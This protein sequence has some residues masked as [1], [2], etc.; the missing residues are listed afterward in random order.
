MV[1]QTSCK[2]EYVK[3]MHLGQK[4]FR[5]LTAAGK[6]PNPAA[7]E[8]LLP[9]LSRCAVTELPVQEIPVDRIARRSFTRRI[10]SSSVRTKKPQRI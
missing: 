2:E 9:E 3:A 5:E 4:E 7:L 10:S 6:D 8:A 1:E